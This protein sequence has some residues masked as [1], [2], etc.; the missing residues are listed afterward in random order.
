MTKKA[1]IADGKF[2]AAELRAV[3]ESA[4]PDFVV[5]ADR[6]PEARE[7]DESA[8]AARALYG[9]PVVRFPPLPP[10]RAPDDGGPYPG[11]DLGPHAVSVILTAETWGFPIE[12]YA[13]SQR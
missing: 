10:G 2:D 3:L 5:V 6:G 13:K 7:R 9:K 1:L 11:F 12:I 4:D 8:V